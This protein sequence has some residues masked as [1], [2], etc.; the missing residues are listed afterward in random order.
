AFTVTAGDGRLASGPVAVAVTVNTAPRVTLQ[1]AD[2][3]AFAGTVVRFTAAADASPAPSVRWQASTDGGGTFADIP[4][5][6]ASTY[7]FNAA[8]TDNGSL[9]RAVFTSAAASVPSDA[10]AL[11]VSP[12][13]TVVTGPAPQTV[14]VGSAAVF[15]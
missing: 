10:A 9:Y 3:V 2:A 7:T 12:G 13:L 4:G 6:T 1:P 5:A 15:A 14:R 8:A 11:T